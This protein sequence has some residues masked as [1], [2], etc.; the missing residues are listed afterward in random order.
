MRQVDFSQGKIFRNI[1]AIS[2]PMLAAQIVNLLYNIVDRIYIARIPE[3]GTE[4]LGAVGV[5]F[6]AVIIITAFTNMF[7]SG[8]SPLFSMA[9]GR[10]DREG[11]AAIQNTAFFLLL[12]TAVGITAVGEL[13][14]RP[15]L[16]LFGASEEA[17][18]YALPYMR[19]Y[20]LGTIFSMTAAGMN[21]FINAQG[22]STVG[23][24]TVLIGAVLNIVLDPVFIF[25]FGMGVRG[26][27]IATV[28][29]QACSA[30]FVLQFLFGKRAE[31]RLHIMTREE[32]RGCTKRAG[33]IIGLGMAAFVMQLT[34]SLVLI[35]S[36]SVL[37]RTGGDLYVTVMTIAN[38]SRQIFETPMT[39]FT[40]GTSPVLSYNYGARRPARVRRAYWIMFAINMVYSIAVWIWL[41][42]QPETAIAIFSSDPVIMKDAVHAFHIYFSAF[43]FMVF[44]HCSQMMFKSLGMKK[45]AI[46]FSIFR[47][48]ILVAPLT[49]ILAYGCHM[50]TDGVFAAEPISNVIGGLACFFTMLITVMRPLKKQ[51]KEQK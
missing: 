26:A 1:M 45:H 17:M 6:S 4:A 14:A 8:G 3:T 32:I 39:A 5:C 2:L 35:C 43:V 13:I 30:C 36:N 18:V 48:G 42:L 24:T 21:R 23:M 33:D 46:F 11:A 7:G 20:L 47:K 51:E 40:E 37:S 15:M 44:Q 16:S 28:I 25:A 41:R 22:F 49:Y 34:N 31:Y 50:G 19:I 29:S 10:Q 27:A 38:S 9:R 12:V